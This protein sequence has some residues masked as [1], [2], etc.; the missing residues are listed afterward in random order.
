MV[1]ALLQ[2]HIDKIQPYFTRI[3]KQTT[4][5]NNSNHV[6]GDVYHIQRINIVRQP[7]FRRGY[8]HWQW[9]RAPYQ[10]PW[11]VWAA[12]KPQRNPKWIITTQ[13]NNKS[14]HRTWILVIHVRHLRP[15]V[16]KVR[17][18]NRQRPSPHNILIALLLQR[19]LIMSS[20]KKISHK[21]RK[22]HSYI[23]SLF[24]Y[25]NR[26][27]SITTRLMVRMRRRT[28]ATRRRTRHG[29]P[30]FVFHSPMPR[31]IVKM[32]FIP[33]NGYYHILKPRYGMKWI[34]S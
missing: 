10:A 11:I 14:W 33:Y 15:I 26:V 12:T 29:R 30:H 22:N 20:I 21:K 24:R 4:I 3:L 9:L 6:I 19:L 31:P 8:N 18:I 32:R 28:K 13:N 17:G 2:H 27:G 25:Q 5:H 23:I 34:D 16:D 1:Q 7:H